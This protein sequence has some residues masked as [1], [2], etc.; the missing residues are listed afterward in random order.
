LT[1]GV[2]GYMEWE[3]GERKSIKD[4]EDII[5]NSN[6]IAITHPLI[7]QLYDQYSQTMIGQHDVF[8]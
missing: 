4:K 1:A 6:Q 3:K 8:V 5:D 2:L 7:S